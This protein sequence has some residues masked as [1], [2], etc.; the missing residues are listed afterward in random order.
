MRYRQFLNR[1]GDR[2]LA[3]ALAFG[4]LVETW[5][6][7]QRPDALSISGAERALLVLGGLALAISIGSRRRIPLLVL[8]MAIANLTLNFVVA[9]GVHDSM[10]GAIAI[11]I[12]VYSA[13]VYTSGRS[14][15]MAFLGTAAL[16][17]LINLQGTRPSWALSDMLFLSMVILGPWIAGKTVRHHREREHLLE[18][19]NVEMDRQLE[20]K[21]RIALSEERSRIARE[22]HDVVAHGITVMVLQARG[23]RRSLTAAPDEAAEAFDAIETTGRQALTEMRRMLGLLQ[24]DAEAPNL[25][26]H[27]SLRR[28]P[29]LVRQVDEA[30]LPVELT[31]EG[32]PVPLPPGIELTAYRIV[33]E[34]LTNSLKH[35]GDTTARVVVRYGA[36]AIDLEIADRGSGPNGQPVGGRGLIGMRERVAM[37]GGDIYTGPGEDG[38]FTVKVLLPFEQ[39]QP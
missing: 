28:L 39:E 10:A 7:S 38:G 30:G 4:F 22:M 5:V 11:L 19:L 35:A 37:Y 12:G 33:Q 21:Q 9:R 36:N 13:A 3:L 15:Y 20:Q 25:A 34:A 1:H 27:P 17:P 31:L 14:T 23:G 24:R 2:G 6:N 26:P 18:D 8:A 29:E 16:I 32:D